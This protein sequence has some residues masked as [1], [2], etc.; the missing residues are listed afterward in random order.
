MNKEIFVEMIILKG[1]LVFVCSLAL[2]YVLHNSC[3]MVREVLNGSCAMV[4]NVQNDSCVCTVVLDLL[5]YSC[6]MV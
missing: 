5:Y 4:L 3:T 2:L 6:T 1:C